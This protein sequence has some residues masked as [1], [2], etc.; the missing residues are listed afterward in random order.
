MACRFPG[1]GNLQQ[2][3]Q[4]LCDG[5]ESM[6]FFSDEEALAAGVDPSLLANPDYVKV[7]PVLPD[8]EWFDA[9]FFSIT[10]ATRHCLDPQ[11]RVMLECAWETFEVAGYNPHAYA[12]SVGVYAGAVMNTYLVNNL[13]PAQAFQSPQDPSEIFTLDSMGGFKVMVANDKDYLP[14][15]I[16]YKLNLRGPSINVQ[17]ACSTTLVAIHMAAQS[18]RYGEC[19]MALAGGVSIKVPQEAGYLYLDDMIVSPDG[20]CRAFDA[21]PKGPSSATGPAWCYSSGSTKRSPTVTT[22]SRSSKARR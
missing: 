18:V 9:K 4:N 15:R 11:Q 12:G 7:A 1:A 5:V 22:S 21:G 14:T 20:H 13:C 8:I 19:D 3:W 2:F 10:P 17:T 16:S 6:Q